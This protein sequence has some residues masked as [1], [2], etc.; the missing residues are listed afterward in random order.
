MVSSTTLPVSSRRAPRWRISPK[1]DAS[2]G[3]ASCMLMFWALTQISIGRPANALPRLT[4]RSLPRTLPSSLPLL[5]GTSNSSMRLSMIDCGSRPAFSPGSTA[6]TR[7]LRAP[8]SNTLATKLAIASRARSALPWS[9]PYSI[10]VMPP[11]LNGLPVPLRRMSTVTRSRSAW[12]APSSQK[13]LG[14]AVGMSTT[15]TSANPSLSPI[16]AR[17]CAVAAGVSRAKPRGWSAR[18]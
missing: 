9:R 15:A 12:R 3:R 6:W 4:S 17:R 13:T 8:D 14:L 1:T 18:P 5:P 16:H 7:L 11:M 2:C 10:V